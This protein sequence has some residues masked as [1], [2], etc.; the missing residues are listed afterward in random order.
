MGLQWN[1]FIAATLGEQNCMV[2]VKRG[3]TV[4]AEQ[5]QGHTTCIYEAN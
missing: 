4:I 2:A 5:W 3:S 1:P